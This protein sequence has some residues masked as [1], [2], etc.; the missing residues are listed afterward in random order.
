MINGGRANRGNQ[1]QVTS[2]FVITVLFVVL[3]L[4]ILLPTLGKYLDAKHKVE[5]G[6][7]YAAWVPRCC[8]DGVREGRHK[9][10]EAL[11]QAP[12]WIKAL[13]AQAK[14]QRGGFKPVFDS[15]DDVT[16][17]GLSLV[18]GLSA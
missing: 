13:H 5:V 3:P 16:A 17:A 10:F 6:A 2:E 14:F 18:E 15:L 4:M 7:R 11:K 8:V 9:G 1:G 12:G